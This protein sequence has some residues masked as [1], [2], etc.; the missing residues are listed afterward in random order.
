MDG[1]LMVA[2]PQK[3]GTVTY[4]DGDIAPIHQTMVF[5][6]TTEVIPQSAVYHFIQLTNDIA[7]KYGPAMATVIGSGW[8]GSDLEPIVI[9]SSQELTDMRN[10]F[11]NHPHTQELLTGIDQHPTWIPHV[12]GWESSFEKP[13]GEVILFDRLGFW[14]GDVKYEVP[15]YSL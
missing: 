11:F 15:L 6:G 13:F 7:Q 12:A 3:R 8:L 4:K 10:E 1:V 9:T 5:L 2:L 14:Y